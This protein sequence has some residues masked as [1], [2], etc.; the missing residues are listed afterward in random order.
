MATELEWTSA[1][2]LAK[3]IR[4]GKLSPVELVDALLA[5]IERVNPTVNAYCTVTADEARAAAREAEAAAALR[6]RAR[7]AARRAVLAEGPDADARHPHH[8]G[9][10]DLRAQRAQTTTACWCSGCARPAPS[11]SARPTRPS[12]AAS[13]SPTT[14]SSAPPA[15]R[16]RSTDR[17]AARLAGRR[18]PWRPG[19]GRWP[20][21]ATWPP[22]S[23]SRPP[24]AAS[25]ASSRRRGGCRAC[26]TPPA[27]AASRWTARSPAP[28][29]MP[30]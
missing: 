11:C 15:T 29:P 26:R 25:S 2:E 9:L 20:R 23:A 21:A 7:A 17:R 16:G 27:G 19:S 8:D 5:R 4:R 24:G 18:R 10:E 6:R 30:R 14:A 3:L 13:R 12:S 22:R 28:S 1:T